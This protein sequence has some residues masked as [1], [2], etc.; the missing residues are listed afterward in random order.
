MSANDSLVCDR[1]VGVWMYQNSG[2]PEIE[3]K[4]ILQ[5]LDR[6][7]NSITGLDLRFAEGSKEGILCKGVNMTEL[8]AFFSY[9]AGEQTVAQVYMYQILSEF[10]PTLNNYK[11]FALAEDKFQSN[12]LLAKAGIPTSDFYLCHKEELSA[13]NEQFEKWHNKMVY[14]PVDGW[15]GNGMALIENK[16]VLETLMPFINRSDT[17]SVYVERFIKNDYSDFRVDIVD[18]QFVACYG[19]KANGRDWRTN[20]TSG[21]SVILREANDEIIDLA[22]RA[23]AALNLEIGGVDILYDEEKE[24]YVVLEVNGIP[25]FATPEQEEMGL[26]FNDRKIDLIVNMIDRITK[27]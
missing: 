9:N 4:L 26:D 24:E 15:G 13:L 3:Q 14:K 19:R 21:G 11:A 22:I 18:G 7:I 10:I 12:M 20:I 23:T 25:A 5:L 2:G 6:G 16:S 1:K 27:K 8:D 17:R